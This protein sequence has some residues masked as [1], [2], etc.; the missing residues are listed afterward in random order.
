MS[1]LRFKYQSFDFGTFDIHIRSLKDRNQF[2]DENQ[3]AENLGINSTLW[4]IFGQLWASGEVLAKYMVDFDFQG[5]KILEI[6][7]GLGLSS[8]LLNHLDADITATDY[9][10]E[11]ENFLDENVRINNDKKIPFIRENWC[12]SESKLGTYDLIIGSDLLYEEN[13][14]KELSRFLERVSNKSCQII[15]V[16]PGRGQQTKFSKEMLLY[17]FSY[18]QEKPKNTDYLEKPYKGMI[19]VFNR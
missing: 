6:G 18:L 17:G 14:F 8:I 11:V 7:C 10:P 9:H 5:K 3:E 19:S 15:L 13:H 1:K 12:D 4:P 2:S 16:D